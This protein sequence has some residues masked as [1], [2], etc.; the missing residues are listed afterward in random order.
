MSDKAPVL[1]YFMEV[2]PYINDLMVNDISVCL[3][4]C[5]KVLYYKSGRKFDL[6]IQVG[7]ELIPQMA[8]YQAIHQNKRIVTRIDASLH[9]V[10]FIAIAIP[11]YDEVG[12]LVGSAIFTESVDQQDAMKDMAAQFN[13][14]IKTLSENIERITAQAQEIAA[15]SRTMA[16]V[17]AGSQVRMRE[18]DQVL[19]FIKTIASQTNLLGL[20]AAIEAA[21]VGDVGRGFG[22]VAEE[23][24]KLAASSAESIKQID[25]IIKTIQDDS[26]NTYQ[27]MTHI[28]KAIS[29]IA[30]VITGVAGAVQ[31]TR[32]AAEQLDA[33]A[34]S[35]SNEA[36]R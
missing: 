36:N 34:D 11:L 20:N 32:A 4:D 16:Q 1:N 25:S 29:D 3:T 14:N 17:A 2:L 12:G 13:T 26:G 22:V 9:G 27:Q 10:P 18:T 31:E 33:M 5:E 19:G 21:R 28:D 35:L 7:R 30:D 8:A 6:K 23:I 24:R 15:L